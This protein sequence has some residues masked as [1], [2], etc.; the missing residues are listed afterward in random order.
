M[1]AARLGKYACLERERRYLLRQLPAG[2]SEKGEGWHIIDR[3][4]L[5]TRLRL[6]RMTAASGQ[7]TLFK[8]GQKYQAGSQ[9]DTHRT[10]T[11]IYLDEAEYRCLAQLDAQE[12]VKKRYPY[13]YAGRKYSLD[14]FE[15]KLHG[16]ILAEIEAET[17]ADLAGLPL[18]A[19]ALKEV[20]ADPFFTG[21]QL[22]AL[23][24][25]EFQAGLAVRLINR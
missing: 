3:Y 16:L 11:T 23:T 19:F 7:P 10:M 21:G 6:R 9:A 18:P 20:T 15:G 13:D 1:S 8:L 14:V 4:L 5:N 22:A 25:V 12:I 17:E 2:W 24:A